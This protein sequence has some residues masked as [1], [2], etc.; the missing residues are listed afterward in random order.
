[1]SN[2]SKYSVHA[3]DGRTLMY[4]DSDIRYSPETELSLLSAGYTIRRGGK[5][6]TKK[7]IMQN[8]EQNHRN[9]T[10]NPRS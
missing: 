5:R 4:T 9:G 10:L 1:M 2:Q 8:A 7:E 6:I 3:S